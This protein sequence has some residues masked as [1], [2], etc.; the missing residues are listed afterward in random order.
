MASEVRATIVT[1]PVEE[2]YGIGSFVFMSVQL[3]LR[4]FKILMLWTGH[5]MFISL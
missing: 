5:N 3:F 4:V 1:L 2:F